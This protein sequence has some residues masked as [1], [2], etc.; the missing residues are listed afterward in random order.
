MLHSHKK[1][2]LSS[3]KMLPIVVFLMIAGIATALPQSVGVRGQLMCGNAPLPD[4]EVTIWQ[5]RMF[6]SVNLCLFKY[7]NVIDEFFY[8]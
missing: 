6:S 8:M 1:L 4:T 3:L 7:E 5:Y 2:Y